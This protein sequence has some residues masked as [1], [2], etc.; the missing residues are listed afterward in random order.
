MINDNKKQI[1][2]NS[3]IIGILLRFADHRNQ[4]VMGI[5]R[6]NNSLEA[7]LLRLTDFCI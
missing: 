2:E 3:N 5:V 7:K 6:S 1:Y 4:C